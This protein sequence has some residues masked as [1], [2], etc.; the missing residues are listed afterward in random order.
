LLVPSCISLRYLLISSFS[1][2]TIF[3][4]LVSRSFSVLQLC[5]NIQSL[6]IAGFSGD[7]LF[8]LLLILFLCWCLG[9]W[10]WHDYISKW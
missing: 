10:V 2:S 7:I 3:M 1:I 8:W 9:I 6:L 5:W 4:Q